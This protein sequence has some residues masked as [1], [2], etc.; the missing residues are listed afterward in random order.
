MEA[1]GTMIDHITEMAIVTA[2]VRTARAEAVAVEAVGQPPMV[3]GITTVGAAAVEIAEAIST[4]TPVGK[5]RQGTFLA[6]FGL[7]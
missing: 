6:F 5:N 1:V 3:N 4:I 2:T 7:L